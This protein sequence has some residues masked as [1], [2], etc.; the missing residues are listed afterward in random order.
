MTRE[1]FAMLL[2]CILAARATVDIPTVI[3]F[4]DGNASDA[5]IALPEL[6]KRGLK[7]AFFHLRRRIGAPII[8]IARLSRSSSRQAWRSALTAWITET[9]A[10]DE[11]ALNSELGEARRRIEDT[12]GRSVTRQRSL[13]DRIDRRVLARFAGNSSNAST[14]VM[15]ARHDLKLGSSHAYDGQRWQEVDIKRILSVKPSMKTRLC[16]NAAM[17]YKRMR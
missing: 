10:L 8:W 12:C 13:S 17:L 9:G 15:G 1:A 11:A 16:R 14:R 7:A 6:A 5:T 4:D 2:E 3:T